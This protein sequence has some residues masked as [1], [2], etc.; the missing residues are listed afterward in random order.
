MLSS[1]NISIT[2]PYVS[3]DDDDQQSDK[4]ADD[5][6][7]RRPRAFAPVYSKF[8]NANFDSRFLRPN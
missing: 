3:R 2:A 7:S 6:H 5:T 1:L 8:G 4:T